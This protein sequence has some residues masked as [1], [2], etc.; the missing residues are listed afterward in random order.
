MKQ[1]TEE[2]KNEIT[3]SDS[4]E[5]WSEDKKDSIDEITLAEYL[6]RMLEIHNISKINVISN[7]QLDTT[8]G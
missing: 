7:A 5:N 6:K 3:A 8:Y 2:L 4:L 1:S